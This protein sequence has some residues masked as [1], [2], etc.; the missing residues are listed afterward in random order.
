MSALVKFIFVSSREKKKR[1]IFV[2]A[3]AN[4][5]LGPRGVVCGVVCGVV[6][7]VVFGVAVSSNTPW[8]SWQGSTSTAITSQCPHSNSPSATSV[9]LG[10]SMDNSSV[11]LLDITCTVRRVLVDME[12]GRS[13]VWLP[14]PC[15]FFYRARTL[16]ERTIVHRLG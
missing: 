16:R 6:F 10:S 9:V 12:T 2:V 3:Q 7:G 15:L 4:G 11:V 8:I 13:G 1:Y 14:S 5:T